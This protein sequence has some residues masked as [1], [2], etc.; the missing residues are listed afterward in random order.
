MR[1]FLLVLEWTRGP[2]LVTEAEFE[3]RTYRQAKYR[4]VAGR[5]S[6]VAP[7]QQTILKVL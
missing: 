3:D 7:F 1:L 5:R 2:A 4:S 6:D